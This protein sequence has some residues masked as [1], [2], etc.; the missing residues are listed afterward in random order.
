MEALIA[1][2]SVMAV[3]GSAIAIWINTKSGKKWLAN[4]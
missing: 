4:L 1:L 2:F 3:I